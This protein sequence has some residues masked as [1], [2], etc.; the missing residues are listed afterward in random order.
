MQPHVG[1]ESG[2]S[3]DKSSMNRLNTVQLAGIPI[4]AILPLTRREIG[5]EHGRHA[6]AQPFRS[7]RPFSPYFLHRRELR[8]RIMSRLRRTSSS[9]ADSSAC[10]RSRARAAR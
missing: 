10:V 1:H 6:R 3:T 9:S 4:C 2:T 8:C 7:R 5:G